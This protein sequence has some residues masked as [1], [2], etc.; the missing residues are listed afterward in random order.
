MLNTLL[1]L[2]ALLTIIYFAL[3]FYFNGFIARTGE[4]PLI[5]GSVPFFGAV[6]SF[7]KVGLF[8]FTKENAKNYGKIFTVF[9]FGERVH[10]IAD[11]NAFAQIQKKPKTF[12]MNPISKT[13]SKRLNRGK[14][15]LVETEEEDSTAKLREFT[16]MI[17]RYLQGKHLEELTKVYGGL[18]DEKLQETFKKNNQNGS[19]TVNLH[20][21]TR[22]VLYYASSKSLV[23]E[24]FNAQDTQNDFFLFDD[25]LKMLAMGFPPYFFSHVFDAKERVIKEMEKNDISKSSMVIQKIL[26]EVSSTKFGDLAFNILGASQT[27]TI[28]GSFWTLYHVLKNPEIQKKVFSE[29]DEKFTIKN[30]EESI[31][32]METLHGVYMETMRF[33]NAGISLRAALEDTTIE[34]DSKTFNIREGDR[35]YLLPIAYQDEKIY[36]N[37]EKFNPERYKKGNI[38]DDM[39]KASIPF[40]GGIHLCPGRYFAINEIKLYVIL[41][42]KTFNIEIVQEN[43]LKNDYVAGMTMM[44]PVGDLKVKIS[45]K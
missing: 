32:S 14:N 35:M 5:R 1:L 42:L 44:A 22:N 39:K 15:N 10:L 11:H 31:D 3:L 6:L 20:D 29:I 13:M 2:L 16:H 17:N 8:P 23:G 4:P 41:M 37:P 43:D 36:E 28:H 30:Y 27:N 9:L 33:N 25:N 19:M 21:F 38:S 45:L 24:D 26:E 12:S 40:G 7:A 18:L 34:V